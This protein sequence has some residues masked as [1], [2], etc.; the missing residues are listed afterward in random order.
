MSNSF[1][2]SNN[3]QELEAFMLVKQ[4]IPA[5]SNVS[6]NKTKIYNEIMA[7]KCTPRN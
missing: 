7:S 2:F 6:E 5:N 1:L 3:V 4:L